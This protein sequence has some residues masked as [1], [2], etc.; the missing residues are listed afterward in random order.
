MELKGARVQ[1]GQAVLQRKL[2]QGP[3]DDAELDS[4]AVIAMGGVAGEAIKY[5]CFPHTHT[6]SLFNVFS[7]SLPIRSKK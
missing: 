1:L 5:V 4:L 6:L 7:L 3:L 2:Y